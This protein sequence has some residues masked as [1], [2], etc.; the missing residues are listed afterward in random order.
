MGIKSRLM[1]GPN[2]HHPKLSP[3]LKLLSQ[4]VARRR[5]AVET[6]FATL[7][8]R[9]GLS[10]IRYRGLANATG[11]VMIASIAFNMRRWAKIAT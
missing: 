9:M 6:N 3:R 1:R 5:A 4:L 8:R 10:V 2:K 7:K 11:Q